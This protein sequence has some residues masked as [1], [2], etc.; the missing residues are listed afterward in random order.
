[1]AQAGTRE[2][3]RLPS[4]IEQTTPA[5]RTL[6]RA[7]LDPDWS[8]MTLAQLDSALFEN[9]RTMQIFAGTLQLQEEDRDVTA[10]GLLSVLS[11]EADRDFVEAL[12]LNSTE[13]PLSREVIESSIQAL[14][15]KQFERL[16]RQIQADIQ[17]AEKEET[18]SD[19]IDELLLKKEHI[20][21][22]I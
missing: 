12:A 19:R 14:R 21:K 17:K 1:M 10:V 13:L 5:E 7:I 8:D 11:E 22:K 16:S 9:L 15:K 18:P 4:P 3:S 6:L 20:R 2:G